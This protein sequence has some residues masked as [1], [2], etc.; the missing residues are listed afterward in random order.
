MFIKIFN[1]LNINN[2]RTFFGTYPK[3]LILVATAVE[4]YFAP[5]IYYMFQG[6]IFPCLNAAVAR[7]C[8]IN[9]RDRFI[10]FAVQGKLRNNLNIV[11]DV[12]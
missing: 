6:V 2:H 8:P 7:W 11:V 12:V 3:K 9:E 1:G 4:I 5:Q 10:S